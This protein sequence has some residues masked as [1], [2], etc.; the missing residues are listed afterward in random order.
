[1]RPGSAGTAF[2]GNDRALGD[3][4]SYASSHGGGTVAVSSQSAADDEIIEH[5]ALVAGIGG[6]SGQESQTTVSWFAS[7]VRAGHIRW[8]LSEGTGSGGG[9]ASGGRIGA[10]EVLDAVAKA[11]ERVSDFQAGSSSSAAGADGGESATLYD[12]SG[13]VDELL[14]V[15]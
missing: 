14:H 12:C 6:F 4:V 5:G 3:A 7:E 8:V 15:G 2:G 13:R 11:C 1:V 10:R 9:F